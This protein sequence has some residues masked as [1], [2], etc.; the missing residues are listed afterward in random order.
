MQ[1][2][3]QFLKKGFTS[4]LKDFFAG[5]H[6]LASMCHLD[7]AKLGSSTLA[8]SVESPSILFNQTTTSVNNANPILINHDDEENIILS[9]SFD[10]ICQ[11]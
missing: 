8:H 3:I 1:N 7:I 6:K 10:S 5:E 9:Y 11:R 4:P 2:G